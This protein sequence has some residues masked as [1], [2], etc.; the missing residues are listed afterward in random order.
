MRSDVKVWVIFHILD[1]CEREGGRIAECEE[2]DG[3]GHC[4]RLD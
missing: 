2:H 3:S 1:D 4:L